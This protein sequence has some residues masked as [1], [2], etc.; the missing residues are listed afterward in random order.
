MIYYPLFFPELVLT[1]EQLHNLT[2]IEIE[3][4]LQ[5]SRRSLKEFSSLPYPDG[6]ILDQL[7]NR[8]IYDERNYDVD[9]LKTDFQLLDS[10][11]TGTLKLYSFLNIKITSH[12]YKHYLI[13]MLTEIYIYI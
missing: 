10:Q 4:L 8:L 3:K 6:Y 13:H 7:G 9:A 2:L 5:S 12:V 1:E 11:L